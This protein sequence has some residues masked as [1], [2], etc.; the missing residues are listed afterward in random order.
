MKK[1]TFEFYINTSVLRAWLKYLYCEMDPSSDSVVSKSQ[2][3][4][5]G[6]T[7]EIPQGQ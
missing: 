6:G 2:M 1:E 4:S 5:N 7:W 3:E